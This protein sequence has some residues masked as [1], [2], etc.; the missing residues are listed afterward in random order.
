MMD[1]S[2]KPKLFNEMTLEK[3][4]LIFSL[5]EKGQNVYLLNEGRVACFL[6]SK[7]K[8]IIPVFSCKNEGIFGEDA[9]L[10]A[11]GNYRYFAVA[12]EDSHVTLIPRHDVSNVLNEANDW[13]RNILNNISSRVHHTIDMLSE[14][15]II[16]DRLNA[17]EAFSQADEK[18]ILKSLNPEESTSR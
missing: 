6:M 11:E 15:K 12:L 14:H 10:S 3:G 2:I 18:L 5:G 9:I 8:R 16:D 17:D 7:D 13:V 1:L 4:T